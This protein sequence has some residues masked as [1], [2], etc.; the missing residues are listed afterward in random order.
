MKRKSPGLLKSELRKK[1]RPEVDLPTFAS[2]ISEFLDKHLG[3]SAQDQN[4][5]NN[6]AQFLTQKYSVSNRKTGQLRSVIEH[7]PE[8]LAGFLDG[9]SFKK[10]QLLMKADQVPR[11]KKKPRV[12]AKTQAEAALRR[13][14]SKNSYESRRRQFREG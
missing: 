1:L 3:K 11:T 4:L 2:D 7:F 14:K 9:I 12:K 13:K 8:E 6:L 5:A 10:M